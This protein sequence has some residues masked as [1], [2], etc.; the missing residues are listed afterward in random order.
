MPGAAIY[1]TVCEQELV[2]IEGPISYADLSQTL[3]ALLVSCHAA[4]PHHQ[5]LL[6]FEPFELLGTVKP[7]HIECLQPKCRGGGP[8]DLDVPATLVG[9]YVISFHT[10]HEGHRLGI[11][12]GDAEWESPL[13][14]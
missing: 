1:C 10:S 7:L 8:W 11:K 12:Y 6:K 4:K 2:R 5:H 13:L 9:A 14:R 3:Q